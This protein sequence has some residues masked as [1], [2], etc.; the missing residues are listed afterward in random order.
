MITMLDDR[1]DC[2]RA[3]KPFNPAKFNWLLI[4]YEP[5]AGN[6]PIGIWPWATDRPREPINRVKRVQLR[7]KLRNKAMRKLRLVN[8]VVK[9]R[10]RRTQRPKRNS[11]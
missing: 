5:L 11:I 9:H 2:K 3:G 1:H 6:S 4:K 10:N 7:A 8:R